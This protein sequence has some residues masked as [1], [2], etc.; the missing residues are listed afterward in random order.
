MSPASGEEVVQYYNADGYHVGIVGQD[1]MFSTGD[2]AAILNQKNA[3]LNAL[4]QDNEQ[5]RSALRVLEAQRDQ[6]IANHEAAQ[7]YNERLREALEH[8]EAMTT[9]TQL[10][11][12]E[13]MGAMHMLAI[14][15]NQTATA[16]LT[17]TP[18]VE[19]G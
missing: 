7:Q 18:E 4:Q 14:E 2:V 5:Q 8:I 10:G 11:T 9:P 13:Y 12:A 16:A 6:A 1:I 3:R 15:I 17:S 19:Q